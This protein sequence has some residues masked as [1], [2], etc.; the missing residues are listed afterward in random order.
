MW[1]LRLGATED[2][3]GEHFGSR[4]AMRQFESPVQCTGV[5]RAGRRCGIASEASRMLDDLGRSVNEPFLLG[6]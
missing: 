3:R 2:A 6:A 1:S 5:T 4:G